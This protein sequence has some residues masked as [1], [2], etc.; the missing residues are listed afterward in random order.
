MRRPLV[1]FAV[2]VGL[3]APAGL[4]RLG[5][6]SG[7]AHARCTDDGGCVTHA[8]IGVSPN[9]ARGSD[10]VRVSGRLRGAAVIGVRVGLWQR[11]PWQQRYHRIALTRTDRDRRYAFVRRFETSRRLVVVADGARSRTL[12]LP[13]RSS[14][15]LTVRAATVDADE[16][17]T[18]TGRVSPSHAHAFVV[19]E[20][21][22]P[23]GWAWRA[24]VRLS[25]A[26]TYTYRTDFRDGGP[27]RLRAIISG[28]RM[29]A[30]S[31]SSAVRFTVLAGI[32][33]I[34]HVVIIMQQ[35]RS[36]DSYFGTYPRAD[37]IPA[38]AC[39]P[40]PVAGTCIRPY[41][42][43]SDLNLGGPHGAP[44]FI[45]D[46][47]GGRLDGFIRQAEK[48]QDC[49][50]TSLRCR[51]CRI[52]P[53]RC[54]GVVGYHDAREIPNYWTY[55]HDFVLQDHMFQPNASWGGPEHLFQVSEWS[56]FCT[57]PTNAFSCRNQLQPVDAP[58]RYKPNDEKPLYAWTDMTYLL[59]MSD[60]AWAYYVF[61]GTEPGCEEDSALRCR[62]TAP[63]PKTPGIWNP[64]PRFET[65]HEDGQLGNIQSLRRFF[66]AA[67]KG[68]LPAVS[69]I[70]P[71]ERVSEHPP[72]LVSV[73]QTYVTGL[74]NAIMR[75]P[76]WK[77]TAI[78]LSWADWG[79]FYDH[80]VPPTVDENGY[81]LRVPGL[82]ISPFARKGYID[83][84]VLSHDAYNKFIEDDFLGG[85]RLDPSTDGR[86][87]P[88]PDVRESNELLG[89]LTADFDFTQHP[90]P[91]EVLP[92]HPPPGPAS[93]PA[94]G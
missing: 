57:R 50:S 40:D 11:L 72:A 71:N 25:R 51:A 87:D 70:D 43:S 93:R 33:K 82:V 58:S 91:A 19:I 24:R 84:Q 44:A 45:A 16:P 94:K 59:H 6:G 35:N 80:V 31:S 21:R 32:H 53:S 89:D 27:R 88:R 47:D 49:T 20:E 39:V 5:I 79:G 29:N 75:G 18:F 10:R 62:R 30:T 78:F 12:S 74:I 73:G 34:Q 54:T 92:V 86:P 4:G 9:P 56:A 1:R 7:A 81:G 17:A 37:G 36:F 76:D 66:I 48:G 90:R 64:L 28:D 42:D 61:R 41:H 26:S 14:V 8:T 2:V 60:V 77:S 22:Q 52:Q 68:T 69:W 15:T 38:D 46:L 3:V 13:V 67:K 55:A 85:Q 63:V 23:S 65:V 83:H